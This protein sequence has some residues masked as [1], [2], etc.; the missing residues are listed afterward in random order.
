VSTAVEQFRTLHRPG[1]PLVLYN[2][3]DAGSAKAVVEAGAP[4]QASGSYGVAEAHG[5]R[6]GEAVAPDLVLANLRRIVATACVPASLDPE[7]GYGADPVAV[8]EKCRPCA[9]R[10]SRA[11]TWRTACR[12]PAARF[13]RCTG[14]AA[15]GPASAPSGK[16]RRSEQRT[17]E[18]RPTPPV[19]GVRTPSNR[20]ISP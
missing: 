13:R 10:T 12:A 3:W 6:D 18:Q 2:I 17:G 4:A 7:A 19:V 1:E 15:P 8:G 20:R 5:A 16:D 11:S 14:R 9:L